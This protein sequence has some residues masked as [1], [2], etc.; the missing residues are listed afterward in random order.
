MRYQIDQSG[1][2]EQ[3][4]KTTIIA[5]SNG[6]EGTIKLSS[7]D[8]RVLQSIFRKADRLKVFVLQV[9]AATLYLLLEK[10]KIEKTLILVDQEYQGHDNLIR[11]YLIQL[12]QKRGKISLEADHIRFGLVGKTSKVHSVGYKAFKKNRADFSIN[13]EDILALVLL[14]EKP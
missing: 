11:S 13:Y 4:N 3:T 8:K 7:K 6:A 2:I 1:R 12:V 14:Y 5:F 9:F 10:F